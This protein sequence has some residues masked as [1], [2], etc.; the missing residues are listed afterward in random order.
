MKQ[1]EKMREPAAKHGGD[2]EAIVRA[3]AEAERRGEVRRESNSHK[4]TPLAYAE[5]LY[6]DGVRKGWLR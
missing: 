1:R 2:R 5:A 6:N 3:Y 4:I